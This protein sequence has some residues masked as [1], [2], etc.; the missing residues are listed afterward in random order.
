[1]SEKE[2]LSFEEKKVLLLEDLM[3]A[4]KHND[5]VRLLELSEELDEMFV[6]E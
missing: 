6:K 1:M 3:S 2:E 4:C 5:D